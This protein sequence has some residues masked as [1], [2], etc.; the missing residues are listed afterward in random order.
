MFIFNITMK[1][2]KFL[3]W[4]ITAIIIITLLFTIYSLIHKSK[5]FFVKDN[6]QQTNATTINPDNYTSILKDSYENMEAYIGKKIKFSGFVYR[7]YDFNENQFVLAREM[8]VDRT[9]E[10]KAQVVV[11]GFLCNFDGAN[12]YENG[13]WV[14]IEGTIS[15]GF[16]HM[17]IPIV[18][19]TEIKKVDCPENPYV[20]PPDNSYVKTETI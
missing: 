17:D 1:K 3:R 20:Y 8:I 9:S 13:T 7:L 6:I 14:E 2:N 16:Y 11:V 15:K 19:I 10:T 5:R 4:I 12:E 18:E